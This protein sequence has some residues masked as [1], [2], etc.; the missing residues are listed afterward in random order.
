MVKVT[1]VTT[2]SN[3]CLVDAGTLYEKDLYLCSV[4][5]VEAGFAGA[6]SRQCSNLI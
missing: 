5:L 1:C 3:D 6:I 2:S 4:R